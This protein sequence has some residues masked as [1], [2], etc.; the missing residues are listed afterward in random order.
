MEKFKEQIKKDMIEAMK[1]KEAIRL[2]T[3]RS[4]TNAITVAEKNGS[5]KEV[6][7]I[8]VLTTMAKQRRQ[9]I[10]AF[11]S[12]G[13][14]LLADTEKLE[15]SIIE[16]YLPKEM[17]ESEI[18]F[19]IDKLI[20]DRVLTQKD[21]GSIINEFKSKYPGQNGAIISKIV[22]SKLV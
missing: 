6:N 22:K 21:M 12:A 17:S 20:W 8:D 11:E 9:S 5:G 4:I 16:S 18:E 14:S 10:E 19:E 7:H 13:N 3:I 2:T 1:A 15:L